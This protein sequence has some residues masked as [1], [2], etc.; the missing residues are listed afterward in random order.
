MMGVDI[1]MLGL[2]SELVGVLVSNLDLDCALFI[3][4]PKT[5]YEKSENRRQCLVWAEVDTRKTE[6]REKPFFDVYAWDSHF[7]HVAYLFT[8][9][10]FSSE[11]TVANASFLSICLGMAL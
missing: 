3:S 2:A 9:L 6:E 10:S 8:R 1:L 4:L 7:L 11:S 5:H